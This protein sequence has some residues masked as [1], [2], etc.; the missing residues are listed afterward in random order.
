MKAVCA[1]K[2]LHYG[3]ETVRK[4]IAGRSTWPI[5]N[6]I[7]I[8][9]D[10]DYLQLTAYD[11]ELGIQCRVP[12]VIEQ[13]GALTVPARLIAEMLSTL[14]ESEIEISM[15]EQNVVNVKCQSSNY[16]LLGLP[17]EEFRP[18]PEIPDDQSFE[19]SQ[20]ALQEII[21]HIIF[22][23]SSDESR[24]TLTGSLFVLSGNEIKV[25]STDTH[26]LAIR[27]SPVGKATGETQCIIPRR[28]LDEL[29]RLL[30]PEDTPVTVYMTDN[31]V[32]FTINDT[33]IVSTLVEGQFPNYQR[34]IP[35][36]WDKRLTI[37]TEDFLSRIRRASI[38]ARENANRV[39][40]HTEGDRLVITAESGEVG[41]AYEELEIV[42]EGEDIK[43]AFN[44]KY[45]M[46][47]L[48]AV[49]TEGIHIE[50]TGELSPTAMKPVGRDDYLYVLMP[51]QMG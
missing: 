5:L 17:P 43:I 47:F 38:V 6:N 23:I 42:R 10:S 20:A 3:V 25:V 34:V 12:A 44:A 1:R 18:L 15:D 27:T 32:K 41:K 21:R 28:A 29:S 4:A 7:L 14:P 11:L 31:H 37:P 49:G 19:I 33:V 48:S 8:C 13:Q 50:L 46:E 26:R 22:A 39:V 35:S 16:M 40:L 9:T 30:Q 45:L 51:M 2:D 36:E 24:S